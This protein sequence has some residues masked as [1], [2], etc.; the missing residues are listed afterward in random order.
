M[1][2]GFD[3]ADVKQIDKR[4]IYL[5]SGFI[6]QSQELLPSK[7][8]YYNIPELIVQICLIFYHIKEHWDE[9]WC[10]S[11][12]NIDGNIISAKKECYTY[13]TAFLTQIVSNGFHHWK[14]KILAV[15]QNGIDIGICK[16][17]RMETAVKTYFT[18]ERRDGYAYN[19]VSAL[20][21]S[22]E[23]N[24]AD[25]FNIKRCQ[26]DDV[27]D[28]YLDFEK[29]EIK[30]SVNEQDL[31]VAFKDIVHDE[32]RAAVAMKHQFNVALQVQLLLYDNCFKEKN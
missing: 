21:Y 10:K 3:L 14:F 25:S 11:N 23:G 31:G 1:A 26:K 32:Y 17:S 24:K 8:V 30:Y 28:M 16:T 19:T 20:L 27:I 9:K 2:S 18:H 29:S 13:R 7:N 6:H 4:T 22:L 15:P 12:F 5:V